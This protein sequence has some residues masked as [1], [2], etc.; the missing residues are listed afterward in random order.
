MAFGTYI[1]AIYQVR[2]DLQTAVQAGMAGDPQQALQGAE[3]LKASMKAFRDQTTAPLERAEEQ[4]QALCQRYNLPQQFA[5][6]DSAEAPVTGG[7][8]VM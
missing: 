3:G 2:Q 5:I 4:L 6:G 8:P 7:L 1:G